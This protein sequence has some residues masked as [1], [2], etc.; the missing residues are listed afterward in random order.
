VWKRDH[1][2]NLMDI[3]DAAQNLR[4]MMMKTPGQR[5]QSVQTIIGRLCAGETLET[6][7]A[8]FHL[9]LPGNLISA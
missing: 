7:H 4:A 2:V 3:E 6:K 9:Y 5:A 8:F 1:S